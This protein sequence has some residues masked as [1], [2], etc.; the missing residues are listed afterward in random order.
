ML[1]VMIRPELFSLPLVSGSASMVGMSFYL[2]S[3]LLNIVVSQILKS[4]K[5]E[6]QKVAKL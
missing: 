5:L 4:H 2:K 6:R 1:A 3:Y